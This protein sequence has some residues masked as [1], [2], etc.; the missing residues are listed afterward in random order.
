MTEP[1]KRGVGAPT[2][3]RPEYCER[4]IELGKEGKSM[5]QMC[6]AFDISRQTIDNWA[7]QF[8][9]FA[10]ALARAK[11]H[12]QAWW[13]DTG[14]AGMFADKFNAAVWKKSV[15]SRFKEDYT[16]RRDMDLRSGDGS[17][18][19]PS[20]IEIHAVFPDHDKSQD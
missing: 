15:E 8:D 10:D 9:D 13:E 16:E 18:S 19:P 20:V 11:V 5:A 4:V 7:M 17:M 6:A 3:Y 14:Q 2:K 12:A 1:K